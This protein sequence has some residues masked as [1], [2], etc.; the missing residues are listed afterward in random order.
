[1]IPAP[2]QE[3]GESALPCRFPYPNCFLHPASLC[4]ASDTRI[5]IVS[6]FSTGSLA[7]SG[8]GNSC[9]STKYAPVRVS[10]VTSRMFSP[11]SFLRLPD[12]VSSGTFNIS[13][14]PKITGLQIPCEFWYDNNVGDKKR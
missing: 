10:L 13:D 6:L 7:A 3:K 12:V 4:P 14:F 8:F 9:T 11:E 2:G 1:M 5:S